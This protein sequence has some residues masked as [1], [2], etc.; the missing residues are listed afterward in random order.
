MHK[1]NL[2]FDKEITNPTHDSM[3]IYKMLYVTIIEQGIIIYSKNDAWL[4][5]SENKT[6]K[7]RIYNSV[8]KQTKMRAGVLKK[9]HMAPLSF[10][11]SSGK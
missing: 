1:S 10:S 7:K 4:N 8:N 6:M 9:E 3:I 2:L 5:Q 11:T